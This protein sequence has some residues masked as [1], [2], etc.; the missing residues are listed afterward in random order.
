[1]NCKLKLLC[2]NTSHPLGSLQVE[3]LTHFFEEVSM[4]LSHFAGENVQTQFFGT[5]GV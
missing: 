2:D 4:E 5:T 1:V 3:K